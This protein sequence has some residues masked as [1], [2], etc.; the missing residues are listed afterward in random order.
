METT[1]IEPCLVRID[2]GTHAV[3]VHRKFVGIVAKT[4]AGGY[5]AMEWN[6]GS[7]CCDFKNK[8]EAVAWVIE[9]MPNV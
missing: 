7:H 1:T 6:G 3:T 5:E 9:M 8:K 4:H 2:S